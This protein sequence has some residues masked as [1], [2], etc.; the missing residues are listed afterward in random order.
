MY[1]NP[2]YLKNGGICPPK[3]ILKS[4]I[5][6][7][8]KMQVAK[9]INIGGKKGIK[10]ESKSNIY[11]CLNNQT[12]FKPIPKQRCIINEISNKDGKARKR[13]CCS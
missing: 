12:V 2:C 5:N 8:S 13:L 10:L 7:S 1:K 4:N 11:G 3:E 6:Q 9:I